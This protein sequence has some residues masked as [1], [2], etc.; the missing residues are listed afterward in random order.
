MLREHGIDS[1]CR[2]HGAA[3]V[4]LARER[5]VRAARSRGDG[6]RGGQRGVA[7]QHVTLACVAAQELEV[8]VERVGRLIFKLRECV[9]LL[10]QCGGGHADRRQRQRASERA[11]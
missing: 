9:R 5:R 6:T 3:A 8:V 7:A 11:E 10:I 4:A 2:E 1:I